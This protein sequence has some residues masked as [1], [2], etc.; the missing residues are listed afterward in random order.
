MLRTPIAVAF[1]DL[2]ND[3]LSD[4]FSASNLAGLASLVYPFPFSAL[5][6]FKVEPKSVLITKRLDFAKKIFYCWFHVSAA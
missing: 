4:S 2:I 3:F 5:C 1:Y 6:H